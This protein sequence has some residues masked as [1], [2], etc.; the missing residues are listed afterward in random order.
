MNELDLE[1]K[2][3]VSWLSEFSDEELNVLNSIGIIDPT[4]YLFFD[5]EMSFLAK[6]LANNKLIDYPELFEEFLYRYLF[7]IPSF[8]SKQ[9]KKEH[10]LNNNNYKSWFN[11]RKQFFNTLELAVLSSS[12]NSQFKKDYLRWD[13]DPINSSSKECQ[14]LHHM[15][16]NSC[17][18]SFLKLAISHWSEYQNGCRCS[19]HTITEKEYSDSTESF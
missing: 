14:K 13:A 19:L 4:D 16:F 17:D 10:L 11:K 2:N 7:L 1:K 9:T 18:A 8:V 12:F 5:N 6:N 15:V 3:Y